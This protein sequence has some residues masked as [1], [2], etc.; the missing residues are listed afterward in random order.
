LEAVKQRRHSNQRKRKRHQHQ[1][2][3]S[4]R[5]SWLLD[6]ESDPDSADEQTSNSS[7]TQRMLG[8]ER[9]TVGDNSVSPEPLKNISEKVKQEGV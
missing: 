2:D 3:G 1:R 6:T 5:S 9:R 7:E 4:R 8:K